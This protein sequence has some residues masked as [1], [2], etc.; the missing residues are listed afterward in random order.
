MWWIS[1][2]F[3]LILNS[4][5]LIGIEDIGS[6]MNISKQH[7]QLFD[8]SSFYGKM[9]SISGIQFHSPPGLCALECIELDSCVAFSHNATDRTCTRTSEPC[10]LA[11]PATGRV[12]MY[13]VLLEKPVDKC[14]GWVTLIPLDPDIDRMLTSDRPDFR[15]ARLTKNDI[16][17]IAVVGYQSN[18]YC[19]AGYSTIEVESIRGPEWACERLHIADDCT[20]FWVPYS[21]GDTLPTRAVTGGAMTT[22]GNVMYVTKFFAIVYGTVQMSVI[23]HYT[24]EAQETRSSIGGD[25]KLT[26]ATMELLV[27]LV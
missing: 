8:M 12:F 2:N 17:D 25:Q 14:F 24:E 26:S 4:V 9:C 16:T 15:V 19:Y 20:A 5:Q 13:A 21:A 23:G 27:I 22:G 7:C 6:F 3:P 18:N 11:L 1:F 10:P